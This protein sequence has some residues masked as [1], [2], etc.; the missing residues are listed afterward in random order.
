MIVSSRV[1]AALSAAIAE[2]ATCGY[3]RRSRSPPDDSLQLD[4]IGTITGE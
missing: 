4:A 1:S 2:P 3:V